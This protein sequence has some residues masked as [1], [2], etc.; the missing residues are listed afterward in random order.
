MS[1]RD[2]ERAADRINRITRDPIY[3]DLERRRK[4]LF[5][6]IDDPLSKFV[7]ADFRAIDALRKDFSETLETSGASAR[8]AEALN[9][10]ENTLSVRAAREQFDEIRRQ[11]A[12]SLS[13]ADLKHLRLSTLASDKAAQA[14]TGVMEANAAMTKQ[15]MDA[16]P[17]S[18]VHATPF[19]TVF[20]D[21]QSRMAEIMPRSPSFSTM[22][23]VAELN[24]VA[25]FGG[26]EILANFKVLAAFNTGG[27]AL[28]RAVAMLAP[29][30]VDYDVTF[31]A[32]LTAG[33]LRSD[34]FSALYASSALMRF[35]TNTEAR[36]SDI[37]FE[38]D[39]IDENAANL[40][41]AWLKETFDLVKEALENA[42]TPFERLHLL[43]F[44][45]SVF[46][47][48]IPV[49]GLLISHQSMNVAQEAAESSSRDAAE[50]RAVIREQQEEIRN[51][52]REE[53]AA[54]RAAIEESADKAANAIKDAFDALTPI[55]ESKY[56]FIREHASLYSEA[57]ESSEVLMAM[58]PNQ[59]ITVLKE[60]GDWAAITFYDHVGGKP[61]SGWVRVEAIRPSE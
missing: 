1:G 58:Y 47:V 48:V 3:E 13:D 21:M 14:V 50:T 24:T 55:D 45:Y 28:P 46:V 54:T 10:I 53:G 60:E 22:Q 56:A 25:N 4:L 57:E 35:M 19:K 43:R 37:D 52:I 34:S 16:M 42:K 61:V 9:E 41:S 6:E 40:I 18:I 8:M 30:T 11:Q 15:V 36:L 39:E 33:V 20:D 44:A 26:N 7:K 23:A 32:M 59:E 51:A 31:Q 29:V 49:W 2:W 17:G 27:F 5:P 12:S 38:E